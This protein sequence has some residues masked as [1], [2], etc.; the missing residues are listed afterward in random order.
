M[1]VGGEEEEEGKGGVGEP[2]RKGS[3]NIVTAAYGNYLRLCWRRSPLQAPESLPE[4]RRPWSRTATLRSDCYTDRSH[5]GLSD[6]DGWGK[7]PTP[8]ILF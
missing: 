3:A 7:W 4:T 2:G 6:R 1:G 8:H 5:S